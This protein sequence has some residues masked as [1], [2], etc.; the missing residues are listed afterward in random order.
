MIPKIIHYCWFGKKPLPETALK[1]IR[2]WRRYFPDYEIWQWSEVTREENGADGVA[3]KVMAFDIESVI[4]T[5][6]AYEARKYAFVSDYVRFMVLERYGGVYFDT[7]VEVIKDM[8]PIIERGPYMGCEMKNGVVNPGLGIAAEPHMELYKEILANYGGMRF[9]NNDGSMN[10]YSMIPMVTEMMKR[11]GL[12]DGEHVQMV[13]GVWVYPVEY[14]NPLD[15][16]TGRLYLTENT[17]SI[18]WYDASW[19]A[20]QPWWMK[21]LKQWY[22]RLIGLDGRN[23]K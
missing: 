19:T 12:K 20:A 8:S 3:D 1:C 9:L 4:Y 11:D 14:F 2:S 17:Y 15:S 23:G 16:L 6:E 18:H 5:K 7:D 22:H 13:R 21:K 10:G